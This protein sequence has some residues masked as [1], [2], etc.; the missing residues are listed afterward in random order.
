[1]AAG[2]SSD[3]RFAGKLSELKSSTKLR[4]TVSDRVLALFY[5]NGRVYALDHF[6]YREWPYKSNL[7]L[8]FLLLLIATD[9][10]GPLSLGDI[11]VR[12]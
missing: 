7:F 8:H 12:V 5:A 4:V 6:C 2:T 10:G 3:Y 11:E 9:T 1:M